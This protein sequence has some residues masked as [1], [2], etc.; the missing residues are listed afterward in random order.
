MH[1]YQD[2]MGHIIHLKTPPLRVVSL[3]PSQSELLWDLG[4]R[5]ELVGITKFCIHPEEMF[6]TVTRVGGTKQLHLK[7]I[8]DLKPDLIIGNKEENEQEQILELQREFPVWMSDIHTLEEAGD[9]MT[10]LGDLLGRQQQAADLVMRLHASTERVRGLFGGQRTL[11]FIWNKPY[12]VAAG[13][14]FI[15]HVLNHLGLR[16]AAAHLDRYPEMD[17]QTL[18]ETAPELCLL[19]SEPF[20][21]REQ[22]VKALQEQLPGCRVE[23][24]DGEVFSWYGSRLL[25]LEAYARELKQRLSTSFPD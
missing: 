13:Q 22:H 16:N 21:F 15:G 5:Q 7:K 2:Q 17:L 1:T 25:H 19:S 20:P 6:R 24:V 3:V 14:T 10:R 9:M 23:I 4:L 12:M 8:R 18:R 11:Y